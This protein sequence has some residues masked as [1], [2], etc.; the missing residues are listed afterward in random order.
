MN[1]EVLQCSLL[2]N[3]INFLIYVYSN[4]WITS[5]FSFLRSDQGHG[6]ENTRNPRKSI[7]ST[8]TQIGLSM[9]TKIKNDKR[10]SQCK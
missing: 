4:E 2:L 6:R 10:T 1:N 3:E 5:N 8:S 7:H 9:K